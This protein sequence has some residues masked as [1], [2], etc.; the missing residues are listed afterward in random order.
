MA[1]TTHGTAHIYGVDGT[2]G[3]ATVLGFDDD[4][5]PEVQDDT[6]NESGLDIEH[7]Y[8]GQR[9]TATLRLRIRTGYTRPTPGA[10]LT[11][12]SRA[13]EVTTTGKATGNEQFQEM[14]VSLLRTSLITPS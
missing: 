3:L 1:A 8:D 6:K 4:H 12:D 10:V 13:Y 2:Q 9:E 5:A 14:T 7:R 11:Y